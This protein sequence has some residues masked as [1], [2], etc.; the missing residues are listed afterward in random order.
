MTGKFGFLSSFK[1]IMSKSLRKK[2]T[3]FDLALTC[4]F[5]SY[6]VSRLVEN[7]KVLL[8][9]DSELCSPSGGSIYWSEGYFR[10]LDKLLLQ[11]FLCWNQLENRSGSKWDPRKRLVGNYC[12]NTLS[13]STRLR[14]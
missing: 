7:S 3:T 12:Q 9:S 13:P 2:K 10:I 6:D 1:L 4:C 5:V 8:L 11:I 14:V